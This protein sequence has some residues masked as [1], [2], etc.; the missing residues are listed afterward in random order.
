MNRLLRTLGNTK[1]WGRKRKVAKDGCVFQPATYKEGT[2]SDI[3]QGNP[4][5]C[6]NSMAREEPGMYVS[7]SISP[8]SG[9]VNYLACF[10]EG[11]KW[12]QLSE[13]ML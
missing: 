7:T 12:V 6:S 9:G 2:W 4:Q 10:W 11:L 1:K 5:G 13:G 3:P 8:V